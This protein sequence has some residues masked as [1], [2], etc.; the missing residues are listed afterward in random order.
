MLLDNPANLDELAS[1]VRKVKSVI[2]AIKDLMDNLELKVCLV[3]GIYAEFFGIIF[4]L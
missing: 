1:R 3:L 4:S 2:R